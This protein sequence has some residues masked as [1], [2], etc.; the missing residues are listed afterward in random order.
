MH[1]IR[2]LPDL[3]N[4][5]SQAGRKRRREQQVVGLLSS[6]KL[7]AFQTTEFVNVYSFAGA[8]SALVSLECTISPSMQPLAISSCR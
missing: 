7:M 2:S 3:N 6:G 8:Q 5:I 4:L 1:S